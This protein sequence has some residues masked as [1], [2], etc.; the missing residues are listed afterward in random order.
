MSGRRLCPATG[1]ELT[2]TACSLTRKTGRLKLCGECS[3]PGDPKRD[4]CRYCGRLRVDVGRLN[5][6]GLCPT[7]SSTKNGASAGKEETVTREYNFGECAECGAPATRRKRGDSPA[8]CEEHFL[9]RKEKKKGPT[10]ERKSSPRSNPAPELKR[11]REDLEAPRPPTQRP[12][13]QIPVQTVEDHTLSRMVGKAVDSLHTVVTDSD[14]PLEIRGRTMLEMAAA[15]NNISKV[16][17][18]HAERMARSESR[19]VE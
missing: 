8:V 14:L 12:S 16:A 17:L 9:A 11:E 1:E 6:D 4:E 7:C 15:A 3:P 5:E 19:R 18:I 13:P 2:L 10:P